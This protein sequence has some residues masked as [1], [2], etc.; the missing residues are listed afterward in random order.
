MPSQPMSKLTRL[1]LRIPRLLDAVAEGPLA[2]ALLFLLCLAMIATAA[3]M[4]FGH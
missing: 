3:W 4:R 1:S 2:V